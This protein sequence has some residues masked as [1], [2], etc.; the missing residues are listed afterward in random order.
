MGEEVAIAEFLF[1]ITKLPSLL[2]AHSGLI[3]ELE[4]KLTKVSDYIVHSIF[5]PRIVEIAR[6]DVVKAKFILF[7]LRESI[8]IDLEIAANG[9]LIP[10]QGKY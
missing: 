1:R 5:D 7:Q 9:A 3:I 4:A 2:E 10:F 6:M 8:C